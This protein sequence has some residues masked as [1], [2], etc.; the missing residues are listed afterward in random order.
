MAPNIG[1][2]KRMAGQLPPVRSDQTLHQQLLWFQVSSFWFT[3]GNIKKALA[4]SRQS[5]IRKFFLK[6]GN[7]FLSINL[8]FNWNLINNSSFGWFC[9]CILFYGLTKINLIITFKNKIS[10]I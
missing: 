2:K 8:K 10:K 6:W 3:A 9:V 5:C 1:S 7:Y 4:H